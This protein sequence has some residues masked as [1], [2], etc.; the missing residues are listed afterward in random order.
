MTYEEIKDAARRVEQRE[1]PSMSN[2]PY[3]W[4]NAVPTPWDDGHW[5]QD[6]QP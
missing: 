2:N 6:G 1:N 5:D 3:V 4:D